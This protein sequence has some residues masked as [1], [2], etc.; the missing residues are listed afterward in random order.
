[1]KNTA[2]GNNNGIVTDNIGNVRNNFAIVA[3]NNT[4]VVNNIGIVIDNIINVVIDK[5]MLTTTEALLMK[6][7]IYFIN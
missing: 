4:N 3:N 7:I 6:I 1:M 5:R 2:V